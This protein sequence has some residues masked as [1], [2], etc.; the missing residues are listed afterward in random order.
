MIIIK[1]G[2]SVITDKSQYRT[3]RQETVAR[4]CQEI[5]QSRMNVIVAHGA[6]SFGHVMAKK[7]ALNYGLVDFE[8]V[9]AV[10]HVQYD[11]RDLSQRV[12]NEF[13]AAGMPAV[14]VA[15]GSCFVMDNGKLI[16]NDTEAIRKL[17]HMGI[18]PIMFGDVVMDRSKGFGICSGDQLMELLCDIFKPDGIV[19]VSDID[20]LYTDDPKTN[21][22]AELIPEVTPEVLKRI[23]TESSVDDVTGGVANKME[24]MLRMCKDGREAAL[25]NGNVP[26]RLLGLLTGQDVPCTIAR[27]E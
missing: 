24:A 3:F 26:G 14:S 9:P 22:D 7:F 17:A 23:R 6:G 8:Q 11:V 12:V 5:A 2:G 21:P 10:A 4:L 27:G 13:R 1:L 19:F 15:P 18:M 25:V 16:A 20:G